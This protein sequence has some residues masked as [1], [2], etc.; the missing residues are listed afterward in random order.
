MDGLTE[1]N[2]KWYSFR[3]KADSMTQAVWRTKRQWCVERCL[4]QALNTAS[5]FQRAA[6]ST[7]RRVSRTSCPRTLYHT[8]HTW[9]HNGHGICSDSTL[10]RVYVLQIYTISD[11]PLSDKCCCRQHRTLYPVTKLPHEELQ[12]WSSTYNCMVRNS[13]EEPQ[14]ALKADGENEPDICRSCETANQF[15][16]SHDASTFL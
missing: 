13:L 2:G 4:T 15:S 9:L 7:G 10:E 11:Q 3:C 6:N 14:V 1:C 16:K 8:H 5:S 12:L